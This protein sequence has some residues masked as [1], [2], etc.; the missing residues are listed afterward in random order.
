MNVGDLSQENEAITSNLYP[1]VFAIHFV[2]GMDR[3]HWSHR[4]DRVYCQC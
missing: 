4:D 3:C 1:L 2:L